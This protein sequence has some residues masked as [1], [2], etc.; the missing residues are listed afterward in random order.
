MPAAS[1]G[2]PY[3]GQDSTVATALAYGSILS[4]SLNLYIFQEAV[5][6]L[7]LFRNILWGLLDINLNLEAG[8]FGTG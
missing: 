6:L 7:Q 5:P 2:L 4:G 8:E 3:P 1:F